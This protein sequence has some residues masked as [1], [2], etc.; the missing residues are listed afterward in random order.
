MS[1][2][3]ESKTKYCLVD[4]PLAISFRMGYSARPSLQLVDRLGAAAFVLI[5]YGLL[6]SMAL[7]KAV[8]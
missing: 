5:R 8:K 1:Y 3:F 6:T 4:M 2:L 7:E